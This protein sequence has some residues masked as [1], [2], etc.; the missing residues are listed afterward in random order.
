[1]LKDEGIRPSSPTAQCSLVSP[2]VTFPP[3]GLDSPGPE[4]GEGF[5]GPQAT[6]ALPVLWCS[7]RPAQLLAGAETLQGILVTPTPKPPSASRTMSK[8]RLQPLLQLHPSEGSLMCRD[9][10]EEPFPSLLLCWNRL[11]AIVYLRIRHLACYLPFPLANRSLTR[12]LPPGQMGSIQNQTL[13]AFWYLLILIM[14][15]QLS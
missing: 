7:Q 5:R 2:P 6:L 14:K 9:V 3:A 13:A 1:M 11:Q 8:A 4:W 10:L 12:D 15:W